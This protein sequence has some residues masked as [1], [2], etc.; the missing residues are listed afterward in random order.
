M[1]TQGCFWIMQMKPRSLGPRFR[2][3]DESIN[4]AE[5]V[6]SSLQCPQGM[7]GTEEIAFSGEPATILSL[8]AR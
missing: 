5:Y 3:D 4:S 2:G 8:I 1:Y 7:I 6:F